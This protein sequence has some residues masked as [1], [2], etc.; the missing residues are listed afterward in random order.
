MQP[1]GE[2]DRHA[3]DTAMGFL[4]SPKGPTFIGKAVFGGSGNSEQRSDDDEK[5]E[6]DSYDLERIFPSAVAMQER[7]TPIRQKLPP[8]QD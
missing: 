1:L 3:L 8:P 6:C 2:R 4:P 7:L 5:E